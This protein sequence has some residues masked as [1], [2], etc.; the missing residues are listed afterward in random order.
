MMAKLQAIVSETLLRHLAILLS[1][2]IMTHQNRP[3]YSF[4][5]IY[6]ENAAKV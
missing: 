5:R 4:N 2:D 3:I 1:C 6:I